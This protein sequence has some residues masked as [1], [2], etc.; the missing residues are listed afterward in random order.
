VTI[1]GEQ[2]ENQ[3][4]QSGDKVGVFLVALA[5]V[6]GE[7]VARL[8]QTVARITEIVTRQQDRIDRD[9]VVTL[10]DFDR[11]Q[12]E[13]ATLGD[14]LARMAASP[15]GSR[16]GSDEFVHP[17]YEAIAAISISQLRERFLRHFE[18]EM[19]KSTTSRMFE[20]VEF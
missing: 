3:A 2:T 20:E 4:K 12:Q 5:M 9:L 19:A 16:D 8:E 1:D 10:Q 15:N 13:F 17:G 14:V 7:T 6:L 11:L 18:G